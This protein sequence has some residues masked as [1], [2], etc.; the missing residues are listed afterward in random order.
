MR[1]RH[2]ALRTERLDERLAPAGWYNPWPD[3]AHLS[4][5]FAPDNTQIS[6]S[7]S[8][9][10]ST[11]NALAPTKTWQTTILQAFQTWAV[12]ANINLSVMPDQ[13]QPFGSTGAV[14]GDSRFGDI[15]V[16]AFPMAATSE[17]TASPFDVDAGTWAGDVN[18]NSAA[19]FGLNGSGPYDL[20]TV[21]LHEAGHSFGLPDISDP[22]SIENTA[23]LGPRTGLSAGDVAALQNI[24]G[25]RTPGPYG[26]AA[27]HNTLA[28]ATPLNPLTNTD[29][30]L[31]A[32]VNA[33]IS[34]LNDSD[35]FSFSPLLTLGAVDVG[36]RTSGISLLSPQVTVYNASGQTVASAVN[37]DPLGGGLTI[38]LNGVWPLS[39]YYVRIQSGR[40][41]VFGVGSYQLNVNYLPVVNSL[42]TPLTATVTMAV[43]DLST[44]LTNTLNLN[45]SF[46]TARPLTQPTSTANGHIDYNYRT[47]LTAL[48]N[49]Q[50][51]KL[52][53]PTVPA[54]T[55]NVLTALVWSLQSN[56]LNPQVL[57]FN[58]QQQPVAAQV[59]VNDGFA[60]VLQVP[61]AVSGA[62]YYVEVLPANP[63][64]SQSVGN[65]FMEVDFSSH[66]VQLT[67]YV[68]GTLTSTTP[69]A[70]HTL[71][72]TQNTLFHFVLA[73]STPGSTVS[74]TMQMVITNAAGQVVFSLTSG[75]GEAATGSVYL[76]SGT[77][78]VSFIVA[79]ASGGPP[80]NTN[81]L[82]SGITLTDPQGPDATDPTMDPTSGSTTATDPTY[83]WDGSSSSGVSSTDPSS[84]PYSSGS[85]TG[86]TTP[87]S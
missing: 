68:G 15:R 77:Y 10:F 66:A 85:S 67:N 62:T 24:Y 52:Q 65:Y 57:V 74:T 25:P 34:T 2:T 75:T 46:A 20:F 63:N 35:V 80:P 79:T 43:N 58:A 51:Y 48:S 56:G 29:G 70:S 54:G 41:D 33:D 14:Q 17:A 82:L 1:K 76:L 32:T 55:N 45:N 81:L 69:T 18:L 87:T 84:D 49:T 9:L 8:K 28:T 26:S 78:T 22:T 19:S 60:N 86:S 11:L 21:L 12:N 7:T 50:Y 23:Y 6:N 61:N 71:K 4:L 83:T 37:T 72:L 40:Q 31:S 27:G 44:V 42:L 47:D 36:V 38:H 30:S 16:G 39:T 13:G 64:S 59:L 3:A 73:A 53:A 5:S